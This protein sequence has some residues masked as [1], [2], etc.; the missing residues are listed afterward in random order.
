VAFHAALFWVQLSTGTLFDTS[1]AVRWLS[2][3]VLLGGLYS[4]R[5]SGASPF[6]GRRAVALWL[7][8]GVLHW[9][10]VSADLGTGPALAGRAAELSVVLDLTALTAAPALLL[11]SLWWFAR[12]SRGRSS[13]PAGARWLAATTAANTSL[14]AYSAVLGA[15]PPPNS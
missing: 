10:A 7:L 13:P 9:S 2:G 5:R 4:L 15:R 6:R 1:V 14:D 12:A 3:V 8:V 11:L